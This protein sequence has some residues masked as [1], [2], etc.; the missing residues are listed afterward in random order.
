MLVFLYYFYDIL[1]HVTQLSKFLQKRN[2]KFSDIDPMI[3]ATINS[4]QKEYILTDQ[5]Q[6]FGQKVQIFIDKTN[7]FKNSLITYID[8]N[9]SFIEENYNNFIMNIYNYSTN[10]INELQQRFSN[11]P[12]FTSMKILNLRKQPK[13]SHELLYFGD[14]ELENLLEYYKHLNFHDNIQLP[15]FFN[16]NK[17]REEWVRFKMIITNSFSSNDMEVILSLLI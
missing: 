16:S 14:K 2:L 6:K 12:L 10:I 1:E 3:Q 11:Q 17:C 15:A 13:D 8:H 7:L 5:L 4:I 9:L